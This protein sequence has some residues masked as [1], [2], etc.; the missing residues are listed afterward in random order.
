[1]LSRRVLSALSFCTC[2]AFHCGSTSASSCFAH[3]CWAESSST[4]HVVTFQ[5]KVRPILIFFLRQ[6]HALSPWGS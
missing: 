6:I 5:A 2:L 1:M 4:S 3:Q